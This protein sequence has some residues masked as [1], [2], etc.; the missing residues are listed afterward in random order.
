VA[1]VPSPALPVA[2]KTDDRLQSPNF[3][4]L[5][6]GQPAGAHSS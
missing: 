4:P 6:D 1:E 3:E 5:P 2:L